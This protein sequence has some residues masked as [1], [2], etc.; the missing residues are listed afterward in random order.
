MAE[1]SPRLN[2]QP[3]PASHLNESLEIL[4]PDALPGEGIRK[5]E[6][7]V[8][9]YSVGMVGKEAD[10][11]DPARRDAGVDVPENVFLQVES[12]DAGDSCNDF[13]AGPGKGGEIP[14]NQVGIPSRDLFRT[15]GSACLTSKRNSPVRGA[16]CKI[17]SVGTFPHVSIAVSIP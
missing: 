12:R 4:I 1:S 2:I 11:P 15:T 17:L 14:E 16:A 8:F 13:A 6:L 9:V 10:G 3:H 5:R 7:P